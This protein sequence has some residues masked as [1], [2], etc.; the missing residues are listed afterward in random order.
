MIYELKDRAKAAPLFAGMED[1]MIAS[2][3]Q[4]MM[5]SRIYVTDPEAPRSAMAHLADFAFL[6]GAPD[7]ALVEGKPQGFVVMVPPDEA[8]AQLIEDCFPGV[9]RWTRYAIKKDTTFDRAKLETLAASLPAG[10]EMRR[11]DGDLYDKCLNEPLFTDGV[12]HFG[13]KAA[14]LEQGRGFAV[15]KDGAPVSM[16]SSYTVYREG[17]EIEIDTLESERRKGLATAVG[18]RLILSC[19]DDDLYPSWDAANMD[20]VRLAEKL[21]YAFSHE[22]YCYGIEETNSTIHQE[23]TMDKKTLMGNLAQ[24]LQEKDG[25]NGAWLYA[26]K[27]EIVSKGAIGFR[28]PGD[29]LPITEDTIFQL[30]S[31]SKTF[32]GAATLLVVRQG[33][34]SLEDRITK[35]FPELTAYEGV[36][37][38]HLLNHTSGI[39]DYFDDA[40]WFIDLWKKEQRVPGN[41]EILRFLQETKAKPYFAPGEGLEYSNT[42]YNLLALLVERLSGVPYEEFL[43]RN[44]FEPAGMTATRCCHIRRDGVPFENYAQATVFENGRWVAD[45]DSEEEVDVVAFDGLNGDDYVFTNIFDMLKW[46]RALREGK[47]LTLEEQQLAYTPG[48]LN[49]GEDAVYDAEDGLGY[50]L[51]WA[52]G[53]DEE[54]GLVVSHSGGMPGV[55]TWFERFIDADRVLVILSNRD[56]RDVRAYLGYWNGME[57]IVRDKEPEPIVS[58]EDIAVKDPDK[59]QWESYCGKYEHPED[60]D[61]IVDEVFLKD[62]ELHVNA[63]DD[64]G[65][66]MTFRL[67]PLGENEFGRKGGMLKLTFGENCLMFDDFTCKKL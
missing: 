22:Y 17:I 24:A 65:D 18:A 30:A 3:L 21:G 67:Y 25:F 9:E 4:G 35:Y 61:F 55:S 13:S 56:Y 66:D 48:K 50:G 41:D 12:C 58:I 23:D 47:V 59:S 20:S 2:C 57:A 36:T 42:G 6:A 32:T 39:P 38:R 53:H 49:N 29:T 64:D 31:V 63:I 46:D 28:D 1:S 52:V 51:G 16:A 33:K 26:E 19:L 10:Y 11:I 44:I 40:D 60:A 43:Q 45:V 5:D 8:W 14:Y 37:V 62:G 27:G 15:V 7:R 54:L 34:L